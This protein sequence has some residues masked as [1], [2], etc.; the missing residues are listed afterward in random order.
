[1]YFFKYGI[2]LRRVENSDIELIRVMRNSERVREKMHDQEYITPDRQVLWFD[3]INNVCNY[4][5]LI[6][7]KSRPVGLIQ[8]KDLNFSDRVCEGGIYVWSDSALKD[9]V[10]VKASVIM[11]DFVFLMLQLRSVKTKVRKDNA[12][13]F[14]HNLSMGFE[15]VA[16]ERLVLQRERFLTLAP[17]LRWACSMGKDLAP[18]SI[19]DAF[20]QSKDL[21]SP[22]Y[23]AL[24][25][26]IRD[27]FMKR[28]EV[29][30][31]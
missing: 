20:F 3:C 13:A 21:A 14:R 16:D 25:S 23:T 8:A 29:F 10:G 15:A 17:R 28:I 5:F 11:S 22:L 9:G 1:M 4:F 27:V 12:W 18:V 31:R 2:V 26:Y 19:D 30:T 24:P 7:Y 6:F